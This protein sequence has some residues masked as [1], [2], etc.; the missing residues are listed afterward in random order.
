MSDEASAWVD[1][2]ADN[3]P[4]SVLPKGPLDVLMSLAAEADQDGWCTCSINTICSRT[5]YNRAG[6]LLCVQWCLDRGLI[7]GKPRL[8]SHGRLLGVQLILNQHKPL[9]L[10][11]LAVAGWTW[12]DCMDQT[13]TRGTN[14]AS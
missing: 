11:K 3:L 1:G 6:V 13:P 12:Q 5:R 4:A 14:D 8:D 9:S 7:A 2:M 10:V